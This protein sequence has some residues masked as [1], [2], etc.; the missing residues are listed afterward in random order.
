MNATEENSTSSAQQ[1][2]V[3]VLHELRPKAVSLVDA[4][5]FT[6]TQLCTCIGN[7]NGHPYENLMS[8]VQRTALNYSPEALVLKHIKPIVGRS[9]L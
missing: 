8:E 7:Q 2:V 5:D 6:D 1:Q 9:R 4:F 3:E